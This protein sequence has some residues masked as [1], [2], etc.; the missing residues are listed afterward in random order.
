[1]K[2]DLKRTKVD[3]IEYSVIMISLLYQA[4]PKK[5]SLYSYQCFW[6]IHVVLEIYGT[7]IYGRT[8]SE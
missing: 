6:N 4:E 1:M 2:T 7:N 3:V 8:A 5:F